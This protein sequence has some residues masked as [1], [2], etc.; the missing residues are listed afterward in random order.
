[1]RVI[2]PPWPLYRQLLADP[3]PGWDRPCR[4]WLV[5]R[6]AD[7]S[8][9]LA[10]RRLSVVMD[11]A[12]V[13][14]AAPAAMRPWYPLLDAHVSFVD[15]PGHTRLRSA[16]TAPFKPAALSTLNGLIAALV[17]TVLDRGVALGH[18]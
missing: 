7:V 18:M 6:H 14:R 11:H 15:P 13:A 8:R 2:A 1:P 5:S 9:L 17:D 4:S 16:L 10:D 12:R 3:R